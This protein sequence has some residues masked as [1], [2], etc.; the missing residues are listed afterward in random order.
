MGGVII[1][2][3]KTGFCVESQQEVR[4]KLFKRR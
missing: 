2:V 3:L 4:R 1:L